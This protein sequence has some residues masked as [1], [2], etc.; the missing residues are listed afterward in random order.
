MKLTADQRIKYGQAVWGNFQDKAKTQR[1]MSSAEW[2]VV[3][4]WMDAGIP[5]WCV[6]RGINDF[7]GKPRRLEAVVGSVERVHAYGLDAMMGGER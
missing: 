4:R 3:T 6:L 5:L 1:D 2:L 7:E